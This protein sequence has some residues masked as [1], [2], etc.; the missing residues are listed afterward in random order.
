M[1]FQDDDYLLGVWFATDPANNNWYLFAKRVASGEWYI[2]VTFRFH[3]TNDPFD[4]KDQKNGCCYAV[5][6]EMTEE[7]MLSNITMMFRLVTETKYT[8]FKDV[9]LVQGTPRDFYEIA[10]TK[11][12]MHIKKAGETT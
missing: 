1:E 7:Q 10:K 8:K 12:Y 3:R 6:K 4:D 5:S 11:D 9:V 2:E